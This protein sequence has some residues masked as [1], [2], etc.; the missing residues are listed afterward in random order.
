MASAT[1]DLKRV[2]FPCANPDF[3][4]A[5]GRLRISV[6]CG[7]RRN[8]VGQF[9]RQQCGWS[10]F[11]PC[12]SVYPQQR[13]KENKPVLGDWP[14]WKHYSNQE[15]KSLNSMREI[16]RHLPPASIRRG[17]IY[18]TVNSHILHSQKNSQHASVYGFLRLQ[19]WDNRWSTH[20]ASRSHGTRGPR[21]D[22]S[23]RPLW[24]W[25]TL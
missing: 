14:D 16:K 5:K 20:C 1:A 2:I 24:N 12:G 4:T 7:I 8:V 22:H 6:W 19:E 9:K 10:W 13:P 23:L 21:P 15:Q 17:I 3:E 25:W 18:N 11:W